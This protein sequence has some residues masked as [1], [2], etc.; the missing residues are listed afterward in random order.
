MTRTCGRL[1]RHTI[2]ISNST[3]TISHIDMTIIIQISS[4]NR[5]QISRHCDIYANFRVRLKRDWF[6]WTFDWHPSSWHSFFAVHLPSH[7]TSTQIKYSCT[8]IVGRNGGFWPTFWGDSANLISTG[9]QTRLQWQKGHNIKL[10]LRWSS[11]LIQFI[12]RKT[13]FSHIFPGCQSSRHLE[14]TRSESTS[15]FFVLNC[16]NRARRV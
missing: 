8:Y 15:C 2:N 4:P 12:Q 13:P 14:E 3:Y 6:Y 10:R 1:W 7:K 5:P 11:L 16:A 9:I